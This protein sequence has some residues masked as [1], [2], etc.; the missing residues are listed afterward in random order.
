[1]Q[2]VVFSNLLAMLGDREALQ[3]L[4]DMV[5]GPATP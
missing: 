1:M 2:G 4:M 5:R 3:D